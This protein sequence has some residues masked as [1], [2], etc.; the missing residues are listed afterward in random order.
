MARLHAFTLNARGKT[1]L[2]E[3]LL[4]DDQQKALSTISLIASEALNLN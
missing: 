3:L 2:K 1:F 4:S